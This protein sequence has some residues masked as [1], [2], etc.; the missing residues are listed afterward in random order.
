MR[1][2][3]AAPFERLLSWNSRKKT[4]SQADNLLK[5][6]RFEVTLHEIRL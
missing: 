6:S 1:Y 3:E 4:V 2:L 5:T